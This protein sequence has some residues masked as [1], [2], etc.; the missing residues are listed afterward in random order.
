M[1]FLTQERNLKNFTEKKPL[2][3]FIFKSWMHVVLCIKHIAERVIDPFSK[4]S[5]LRASGRETYILITGF[6]AVCILF[7]FFHEII[8][9]NH[10]CF[11][12]LLQNHVE[13]KKN[14]STLKSVV[15][16]W[17]FTHLK[18]VHTFLKTSNKT[19]VKLRLKH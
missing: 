18:S 3:Y 14:S 11:Q 7:S 10:F 19:P 2:N 15:F 1:H 17:T 13:K 12:H 6:S 8:L 5:H 16:A 9:A 4:S